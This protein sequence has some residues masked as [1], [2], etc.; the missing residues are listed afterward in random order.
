MVFAPPKYLGGQVVS[1]LDDTTT[2]TPLD[3]ISL[4]CES[5]QMPGM[6]FATIDGPPRFG[7]GPI[8]A[9]PYGTIFDDVSCSFI[10]DARGDIHRFFYRWVN[11]IVNFHSRGQSQ[12]K[13]AKGVVS[14]MRTFEVGYKDQFCTDIQ[15][16]VYDGVEGGPSTGG[17]RIMT[18]TLYRAFPK[19]LPSFD[20]NWGTN[21][22]IVRLTIPFAY[23]DFEVEYPA[24][25]PA[26][27]KK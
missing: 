10:V 22:D 23:T 9:I 14:K 18:A 20:L 26:A 7:Y 4:R 16:T 17:N 21:D 24:G 27:T 8:E 12:I 19:L 25:Q 6:S 13:D 15:I 3:R 2:G 5:V 11:T 1:Q